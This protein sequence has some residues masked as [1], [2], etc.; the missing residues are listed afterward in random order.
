MKNLFSLSQCKVRTFSLSGFYLL[1]A[2]LILSTTTVSAQ[3]LVHADNAIQNINVTVNNNRLVF[4]TRDDYERAVGASKPELRKR[5]LDQLKTLK[6]FTSLATAPPKAT[7]RIAGGKPAPS[8]LIDDNDFRSILNPDLVVQIGDHIFKINPASKKV[9]ALPAD[10]ESE[11]ADLLAE[12]TSNPNIRQFSTDDAV[13]DLL[14]SGQESQRCGDSGIGSLENEVD[15]AVHDVEAKCTAQ[16]FKLGVYFSLSAKAVTP[17]IND[18]EVNV[19][20]APVYYHVRCGDTEGP[21]FSSENVSQTQKYYAYR[22]S[23]PLNEVCLRVR[24][25]V[26]ATSKLQGVGPVAFDVPWLAINANATCT[27]TNNTGPTGLDYPHNPASYT[28][29]QYSISKPTIARGPVT[30]WT[31]YPPLPQGLTIDPTTGV[32]DGVPKT[33]AP[34]ADRTVTASGAQGSTTKLL[35]MGPVKSP[36]VPSQLTYPVNP[37][38]YVMNESVIPSAPTYTGGKVTSWSVQ[39][40]LP[41]GLY[42]QTGTDPGG[43]TGYIWGTPTV[44]QPAK[45][46]TITASNA[47]GSATA[48]LNIEV[49]DAGSALSGLTY[50]DN[51]ASYTVGTAIPT[52]KP[53]L[54]SGVPFSGF[55]VVP[56]LPAG[57]T[58]ATTT[59]EIWGTPTQAQGAKTYTVT[60]HGSTAQPG[61]SVQVHITVI[62]PTTTGG[63]SH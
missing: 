40:A 56:S 37:V 43:A 61:A 16:Y 24:F 23:K 3:R 52:N 62:Q 1:G 38:I 39:P 20:L 12:R 29:G 27:G 21:S 34:A 45:N 28:V 6:G 22:G 26:K 2:G 47:G 18:A 60:A 55:T 19:D 50:H 31:I 42:I 4:G 7:E 36:A 14:A 35:H 46:Y 17:G 44:A 10:Q 59:G 25:H 51:P 41:A 58:L 15:K 63:S 13:L 11:Y 49:R 57:L 32:I 48:T 30:V 5:V 33:T 8:A 9:Y 54:A 53:S